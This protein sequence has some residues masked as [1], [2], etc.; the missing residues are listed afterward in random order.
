M[1]GV[2]FIIDRDFE[3]GIDVD[4]TD[5]RLNAG[6]LVLIEP[7]RDGINGIPTTLVNYAADSALAI[8][9]QAIGTIEVRNTLADVGGLAERTAKGG[10]HGIYP[11]DIT[12]HTP[13]GVLSG[14]LPTAIN[15]YFMAH[16]NHAFYISL[17]GV[18]TRN[19]LKS[20]S[21]FTLAGVRSVSNPI[22]AARYTPSVYQQTAN[23]TIVGAKPS[24]NLL[25]R[26]NAAAPNSPWLADGAQPLFDPQDSTN[27]NSVAY[28]LF[29]IGSHSN[30][31]VIAGQPSWVMYSLYLE[32]LTVSGQTYEQ[33]HEKSQAVFDSRFASGGIYSDDTWTIPQ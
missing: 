17:M 29:T 28:E 18:V 19:S 13:R 31:S 24:D 11:Q 4:E 12:N 25:G 16:P 32:D 1:T 3:Y 26:Q 10:L 6:S 14:V 33:A 30:I 2:K 23:G 15:D 7:A 8:M 22:T 20:S 5:T 21:A 9:G 27:V